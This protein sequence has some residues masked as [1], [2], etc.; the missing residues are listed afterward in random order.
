MHT[1]GWSRERA[2][3]YLEH[4]ADQPPEVARR[5][6]FRY[7][8]IPLQALSYYLGARQFEELHSKYGS[9]LAGRFYREI[10]S[11]G[12]VPPKLIDSYLVERLKSPER[13]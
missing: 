9:K 1:A 11:L 7:S 10:L 4:E 3:D 2:A 12:P 8:R 5:E 13:K 6:V